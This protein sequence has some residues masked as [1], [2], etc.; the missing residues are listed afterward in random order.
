[1]VS[2]PKP[3]DPMQTAAA[4]SGMNRDTAVSEQL[5]NMV[6]QRNPYG[7]VTYDQTGTTGY[8]DSSGRWVTLPSFTQTTEFSPEQQT[9]FD[10]TQ[11]AQGN[12]AGLAEDQS[13]IMRERLLDPFE[14]D[15]QDAADWS[16]DLA[17]SRILPQQ[18][19]AGQALRNQLINS[20][21]RPG[22]AAYEREMMR[23]QQ[24]NQDQ[25]NQLALAGRGQAFDEAV[26]T[27]VMPINELSALL[28]GSQVANPAAQSGPTPQTGIAG[29]DY[30]GMVQQNYQN[31]MNSR[32]AAL[33][34]LFGL[35]G[36]LGGALF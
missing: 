33:G 31:Q 13:A 17:S 34:G 6:N 30:T 35:A 16:Y 2:T 15:N 12:L 7:S 22:T 11:A 14:F 5:L 9:I 29:V 25:L 10:R 20:G 1:M 32:G 26:A 18:Q 27:R 19:Q 36:T 3:P 4:Q 23:L 21:L 24:G 8:R 28:S